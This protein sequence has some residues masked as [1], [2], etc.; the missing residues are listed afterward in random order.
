[1]PSVRLQPREPAAYHAHVR[2]RTRT[3][4][5]IALVLICLSAVA[6]QEPAFRAGDDLVLVPVSVTDQSGQFVHGLTS[7]DFDIS[8]DGV[9]R[10]VKQL[11]TER[12]PVSLAI[13]LDIGGS[14]PQ[15]P[16]E[17][18]AEDARW[19]D[20]RGALAWLFTRLGARD[21]VSFAVFND[22]VSASPW[23][24][25]YGSVLGTFDLLRP[26]G[27]S[28]LLKAVEQ[29][30]L[31]FQTARHHRK[32]LLLITDGSD[33]QTPVGDGLPSLPY[34][35]GSRIENTMG[36]SRRRLLRDIAIQESRNA[37]R[38]NDAV[39]Y[40]VGIGT[41]SGVPV[42]INLLDGLT[43]GSGGYTE[44]LRNPWEIAAAVARLWDDLQSQYLLTFEP[45]HS[46]GKYHPIRVRTKDSRLKVRT[47]AGYVAV[48]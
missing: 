27:G 18:L 35:I 44:P 31:V 34:E 8:E 4:T 20:T 3:C 30:G 1:M 40:A 25:E 22:Q 38:T 13:L 15:N 33:T 6:A 42:D 17:R 11:T 10:A 24:Q 41:R 16:Q 43:K 47:R 39:L 7:G 19:S 9:P 45:G 23:T 37:V 46:D 14:M 48:R 32:V 29:I 5:A 26:G 12:V 36:E 21:E 28:A 2:V